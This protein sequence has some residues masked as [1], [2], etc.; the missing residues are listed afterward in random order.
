MKIAYL[1]SSIIP[2]RFANS[3]HVMKMCQAFA[4]NGHDVVLLCRDGNV[5]S[6]NGLDDYAFYGVER[7]FRIKKVLTTHLKGDGYLSAIQSVLIVLKMRP[8]LIY[9]RSIL[10]CF[11]STL[12]GMNTIVEIHQPPKDI[13]GGIE[14]FCFDRIIKSKNLRKIVVISEALGRYIREQ[15][16]VESS[17]VIIAHDGADLPKSTHNEGRQND[18]YQVGYVGQLYKGRGIELIIDMAKRCPWADFNLIGGNESDVNYWR[19]QARDICNMHFFGYLP[20]SEAEKKRLEFDVLLAPYQNEV[21]INSGQDTS[22]WMSPLKIFEYMASNKPIVCSD[23][24]V[25]RE[26]LRNNHNALLCAPAV[27]EKWVGA[28]ELLRDRQDFAKELAANAFNDFQNNY[29]WQSRAE[30]VL[31]G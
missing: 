21:F 15:Y 31:L 25:L 20:P 16:N 9:G 10:G 5:K 23:L 1:S 27:V 19:G 30:K 6:R 26:V 7:N 14:N 2:S 22:K 18:R 28:L 11:L 24:P 17:K 13:E 12:L 8:D 3:V 29:T 4:G